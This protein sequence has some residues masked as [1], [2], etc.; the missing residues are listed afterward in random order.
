MT[1]QGGVLYSAHTDRLVGACVL[2]ACWKLRS[3]KKTI[4][5]GSPAVRS[6]E[7]R[8]RNNRQAGGYFAYCAGLKCV[9]FT[10]VH[11]SPVLVALPYKGKGFL[12]FAT[13]AHLSGGKKTAADHFCFVAVAKL[14]TLSFE[15]FKSKLNFR[16]LPLAFPLNFHLTRGFDLN[17]KVY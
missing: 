13:F 9:V 3:K 1:R 2:A 4:F 16:V 15:G 6:I 8:V 10:S 5:S 11:R 14:I 7:R 12:F 17:Q